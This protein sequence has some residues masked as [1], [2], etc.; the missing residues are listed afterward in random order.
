MANTLL[1]EQGESFNWQKDQIE[2]FKI[3]CNISTITWH[4]KVT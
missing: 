3:I 4:H 2:S 1:I